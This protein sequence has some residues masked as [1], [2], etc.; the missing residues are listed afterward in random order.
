MWLCEHGGTCGDLTCTAGAT[1]DD[2]DGAMKAEIACKAEKGC[3]ECSDFNFGDDC[4][5]NKREHCAEIVCCPE[6]EMEVKGMWGCEHGDNCGDLTC[7]AESAPSG[8]GILS[9]VTY[10]LAIFTFVAVFVGAGY[11]Y[12]TLRRGKDW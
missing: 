5:S 12:V 9:I 7:T 11:L 10:L 6:C 1:C 4:E 8:T 3:S 2:M